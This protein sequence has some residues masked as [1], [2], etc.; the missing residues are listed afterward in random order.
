MNPANILRF[1]NR[2]VIKSIGS[3]TDKIACFS[4]IS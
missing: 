4:H 2:V 3:Q 1:V